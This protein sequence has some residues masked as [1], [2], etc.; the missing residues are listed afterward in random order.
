MAI[1]ET[2]ARRARDRR[3]VLT[4]EHRV[5]SETH[6]GRSYNMIEPSTLALTMLNTRIARPSLEDHAI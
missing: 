5:T 2:S 1:S 3:T 4:F 6:P